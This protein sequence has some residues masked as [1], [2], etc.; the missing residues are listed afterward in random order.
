MRRKG[1]QTRDPEPG[2]AVW[3]PRNRHTAIRRRRAE[4]GRTTF[5]T[6]LSTDS[7]KDSESQG[8]CPKPREHFRGCLSHRQHRRRSAGARQDSRARGLASGRNRGTRDELRGRSEAES[9][10]PGSLDGRTLDGSD[11]RGR[12]SESGSGTSWT[13][14]N[15]WGLEDRCWADGDDGIDDDSPFEDSNSGSHVLA[16]RRWGV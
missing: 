7:E 15:G 16:H 12:G 8:K 3:R 10:R 2:N 14:L 6:R 4:D 13:S 1:S 5:R 11:A 9:I